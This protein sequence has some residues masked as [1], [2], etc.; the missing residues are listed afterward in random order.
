MNLA[1]KP[2]YWP[3]TLA[4]RSVIGADHLPQVF[5]IEPRGQRRR[6]DQIAKHHRQ[7]PAFGAI[8]AKGCGHDARAG[9]ATS[10]I[11]LPHPPQNLAAG[12]FSKS[13]ARQGDGSGTPHWAQKRL[14]AAFSDMHFGQ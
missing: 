6:A 4:N 1:T 14:A 11:G 2:S 3:D 12:S 5:R 13:Q 7:L 10:P 9:A 8:S